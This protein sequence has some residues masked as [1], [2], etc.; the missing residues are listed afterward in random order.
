[1]ADLDLSK[2]KPVGTRIMVTQTTLYSLAIPEGTSHIL[3]QSRVSGSDWSFDLD[4][5][6]P[7]PTD[8]FLLSAEDGKVLLGWVPTLSLNFIQASTNGR[9][10]IQ[11]LQVVR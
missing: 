5:S 3:V 8:G 2:F 7:T 1:M 6:T 11:C 4:G 9:L 10:T